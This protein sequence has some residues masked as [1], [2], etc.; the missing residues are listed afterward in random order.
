MRGG[1]KNNIGE[2]VIFSGKFSMPPSLSAL[3]IQIVALLISLFFFQMVKLVLDKIIPIPLLIFLQAS[4]ASLVAVFCRLDWWWWLIQFFFP[5]AIV[6]LLVAAFPP[7]YYL[8]AFIFLTLLFWSTFRTQ[9]PYYPSK[10]SLLPFVAAQLPIN[11]HRFIDVGSGLGGLLIKLATLRPDCH[12]EGVEIA[13]LPWLISCLKARL[14]RVSINLMLRDYARLN[15]AYYDV[16]F[17]YLSPA[18]MPAL[19]EKGE[20]RNACGNAF[21]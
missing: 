14:A 4:I 20:S 9:V 11:S 21:N 16:V 18:A 1:H 5:I 13:P 7:P 8:I 15:F 19:W 6:A 12:F 17:A 3:L 2:K 10:A